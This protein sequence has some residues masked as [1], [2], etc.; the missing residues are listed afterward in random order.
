[1][2]EVGGENF[3]HIFPFH[4]NSWLY[5]GPAQCFTKPSDKNKTCFKKKYTAQIYS[6][7]RLKCYAST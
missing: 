7:V 4:S 1:M 2:S 6:G 5:I 3:W